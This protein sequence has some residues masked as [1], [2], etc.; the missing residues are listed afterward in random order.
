MGRLVYFGIFLRLHGNV[1][2]FSLWICLDADFLAPWC[3]LWT[4]FALSLC[5]WQS[6]YCLNLWW[7][8]LYV[9]CIWWPLTIGNGN[10]RECLWDTLGFTFCLH[11]IYSFVAFLC[12]LYFIIFYICMQYIF[13][14][15]HICCFQWS[16]YFHSPICFYFS[17]LYHNYSNLRIILLGTL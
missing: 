1:H 8:V 6:C 5:F 16:V 3:V 10:I 17:I 12:M 11:I 9:W 2:G 4:L 15:I 7:V 13:G 14:L